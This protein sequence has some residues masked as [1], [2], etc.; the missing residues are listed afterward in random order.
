MV[1]IRLKINKFGLLSTCITVTVNRERGVKTITHN[2]TC[3]LTI[4]SDGIAD[5][6][7]GAPRVASIDSIDISVC[8]RARVRSVDHVTGLYLS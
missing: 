1:L 5:G 4:C 8:V 6:L 3:N 7:G 2:G